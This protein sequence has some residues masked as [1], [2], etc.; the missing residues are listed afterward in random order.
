MSGCGCKYRIYGGNQASTAAERSDGC[1]KYNIEQY[2]NIQIQKTYPGKKSRIKQKENN[3]SKF[4]EDIKSILHFYKC[5]IGGNNTVFCPKW[6]EL[7]WLFFFSSKTWMK[8][9]NRAEWP[10][11]DIKIPPCP[12]C[13]FGQHEGVDLCKC[14]FPP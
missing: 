7:K 11:I 12:V 4:T 2:S 6:V 3:T 1:Y 5:C 10:S 14:D 9:T 13:L 8:Y